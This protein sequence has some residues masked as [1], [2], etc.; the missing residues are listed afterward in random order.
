MPLSAFR[1]P[2]SADALMLLFCSHISPQRH[3]KSILTTDLV[4]LCTLGCLGASYL[5]KGTSGATHTQSALFKGLHA[6][7]PST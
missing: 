1:F 7:P 6:R 2:L 5:D 3:G 4:V